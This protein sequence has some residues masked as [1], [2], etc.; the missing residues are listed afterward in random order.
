MKTARSFL[1]SCALL[2]AFAGLA[3]T[4]PPAATT[5]FTGDAYPLDTCAVSGEKLGKDAVTVVL[6]D[7]KDKNLNGTQMK[8]CCEKCVASFKADPSKYMP[9]VE[10]Q[11]IKT[12]GN[13]PL[14]TC[15]VMTDEAVDAG[16]KTVVFHN[17]V[18]KFCCKKCIARFEKDP[19][20]FQTSYEAQVIEKQKASYKAAKCPVSG[21]AIKA[22]SADVVIAGRLVRCCCPKCAEK[23][24]ADP[25]GTLANIDAQ[26][27]GAGNVEKRAN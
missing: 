18:Y 24:K 23:A 1:S 8:F 26:V 11:I 20:K 3:L 13:Y 6:S 7:M 2:V 4:A 14:G 19:T 17:R 27:A 12:A 15:L 9:K 10:E 25:K 5:S 21:E 16:S 22:D